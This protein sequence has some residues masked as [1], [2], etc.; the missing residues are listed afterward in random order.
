M[1]GRVGIVQ[2]IG[3]V[4]ATAAPVVT[5][6]TLLTL[7]TYL[8]GAKSKI[9]VQAGSLKKQETSNRATEQPSGGRWSA[10]GGP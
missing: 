5:L 7:L 4:T 9:L 10:V 1:G 3:I 6:L 2:S 8:T